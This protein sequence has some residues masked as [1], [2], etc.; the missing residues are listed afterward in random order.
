MQVNV[1]INADIELTAGYKGKI[2]ET[3]WYRGKTLLFQYLYPFNQTIYQQS[4]DSRID[5]QRIFDEGYEILYINNSNIGDNGVYIASVWFEGAPAPIQATA[6]V[7]VEDLPTITANPKDSNVTLTSNATFT[8]QATAVPPISDYKW[9]FNNTLIIPLSSHY[10]IRGSTLY[11]LSATLDDIGSY[12]CMASNALGQATSKTAFLR[13]LPEK[14][15]ELQSPSNAI[16]VGDSITVSATIIGEP[17]ATTWYF[18]T[19]PLF[20]YLYKGNSNTGIALSKNERIDF[21][22]KGSLGNYHEEMTIRDVLLSDTGVY[23]IQVFFVKGGFTQRLLNYHL[24]VQGPPEIIAAPQNTALFDGETARFSC[25]ASAIPIQT[26]VTWHYQGRLI[27]F[28]SNR[29]SILSNNN[30]L[31]IEDVLLTDAGIYSCVV[32]NS[33]GASPNVSAWL[34]VNV[35]NTVR[36]TPSYAQ[37]NF[38]QNI[39]VTVTIQG[40][41]M[42]SY[43]YFQGK[44]LYQ[45]IFSPMIEIKSM[46]HS[47]MAVQYNS[48]SQYEY[49]QYFSINNTNFLDNGTY[50]LT[51]MFNGQSLMT[52]SKSFQLYVQGPPIILVSPQNQTIRY[53]NGVQFWCLAR[54]IPT[55]I[56]YDWRFNGIP[57]NLSDPRISVSMENSSVL[58]IA[59]VSQ[60]DAGRYTCKPI[61]SRGAGPQVAANLVVLYSPE[62]IQLNPV[63]NIITVNQSNN[64]L[65]ACSVQDRGYPPGNVTWKQTNS[66]SNIITEA[67]SSVHL[68]LIDIASSENGNSYTCIINNEIGVLSIQFSL[69]VQDSNFTIIYLYV[70]AN[71]G[72]PLNFYAYLVAPRINGIQKSITVVQNTGVRIWCNTTANPPAT[73]SISAT[74]TAN[75]NQ[76]IIA[77]GRGLATTNIVPT[78]ADNGAIYTCAASNLLGSV[79][80][81]TTLNILY[82]PSGIYLSLP[83]SVLT[84]RENTTSNINCTIRDRGNPPANATWI[85]NNQVVS[86]GSKTAQ[87]QLSNIK[88]SSKSREYI[89]QAKNPFNTIKDSFA[90]VVQTYPRIAAFPKTIKAIANQNFNLS[91]TAIA[92]PLPNVIISSQG[93]NGPILNSHGISSSSLMLQPLPSENGKILTCQASNIVGSISSTTQ[94]IVLYPPIFTGVLGNGPTLVVAN[95]SQD[96]TL[97]CIAMGNPSNLTYNWIR[98]T[99]QGAEMPPNAIQFPNA[100][101]FISNASVSYDGVY[102]CRANNDI[103][104]AS[105]NVTVRITESPHVLV[106]S[107]TSTSAQSFTK[108]NTVLTCSASGYPLPVIAWKLNGLYLQGQSS[109]NSSVPQS[110]VNNIQILNEVANSVLTSTLNITN[111][112]AANAGTYTCQISNGF[113]RFSYQIALVVNTKT[114]PQPPHLLFTTNITTSA[115]ALSWQA[116]ANGF[117]SQLFMIYYRV[118]NQG[119][120][121]LAGNTTSTNYILSNL[122]HRTTYQIYVIARNSLGYSQPSS[123]LIVTTLTNDTLLLA[124]IGGVIGGVLV[125]LFV[126]IIILLIKRNGN[127]KK[128]AKYSVQQS[129]AKNLKC[130]QELVKRRESNSINAH[131]NPNYDNS[132]QQQSS[133]INEVEAGSSN[134]NS[135]GAATTV[136]AP[137]VENETEITVNDSQVAKVNQIGNDQVETVAQDS[138]VQ[139]TVNNK[140]SEVK[141]A[142][143]ASFQAEVGANCAELEMML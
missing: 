84:V 32:N 141:S 113:G 27:D 107:S 143:T 44:L 71:D 70:S 120:Y 109:I 68:N 103:G 22:Q 53:R 56:Q 115:I 69:V 73:V 57:V 81:T 50:T 8:C 75:A 98:I 40:A 112:V 33:I 83:N 20:T 88:Y 58:T 92:F 128:L 51:V 104:I 1:N 86:T 122:Q 80:G 123:T 65:V 117:L 18:K 138:Q 130:R 74:I 66:S 87:L 127:A 132:T 101:L 42:Q 102:S 37:V 30:T 139:V 135:N 85:I 99:P 28:R 118:E 31:Q 108:E 23:S 5:I 119:D 26:T 91:C 106:N 90:L 77:Q 62:M 67:S 15:V 100:T 82:P 125:L 136:D 41:P 131:S 116:G 76:I 6:S 72:I 78:S 140:E 54:A 29:F 89:C 111:V 137:Q 35:N 13:V 94:L 59:N 96:I 52:V 93:N 3:F 114:I 21:K 124:I 47:R 19:R 126:L 134:S 64:L 49:N 16:M 39:Q 61:N 121:L 34:F 79:Q 133:R 63:Q 25:G 110:L 45:Y 60:Y 129:E 12:S 36:I 9:Y 4:T 11:I 24:T 46:A 48:A 2:L 55:D 38:S 95:R 105:R 142:I 7:I 43:W 17:V 14:Y 97:P 10:V